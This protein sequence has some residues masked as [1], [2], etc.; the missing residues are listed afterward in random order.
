MT[1][2]AYSLACV[3]FAA[4]LMLTRVVTVLG[5]ELAHMRTAFAVLADKSLSEREKETA[6]QR[7]AVRA[8]KGLVQ[9]LV[10]F[11]IVVIATALPV[12]G[13]HIA[14]LAH[15]EAVIDLAMNPVVMA[16]TLAVGVAAVMLAR[17]RSRGEA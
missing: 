7:A 8:V 9:I 1:W 17:R 4:A 6:T 2:A 13:A 12:W 14:G 11:A 10:R 16:V 5:A 15:A 3:A